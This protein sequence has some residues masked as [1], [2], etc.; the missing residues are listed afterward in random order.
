MKTRVTVEK[1]FS[2]RNFIEFLKDL[3]CTPKE[4][5]GEIECGKLIVKTNADMH[6]VQSEVYDWLSLPARKNDFKRIME[7]RDETETE[8]T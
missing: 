8:I 3:L 7:E 5:H 1:T 4:W 2:E 6:K